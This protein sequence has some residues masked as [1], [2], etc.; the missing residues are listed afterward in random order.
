MHCTARHH[1]KFV[2]W[3]K[4]EGL[5]VDVPYDANFV[6]TTLVRIREFYFKHL[7]DGGR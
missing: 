2:V 6:R 5:I 4:A 3:T 1:C 7:L